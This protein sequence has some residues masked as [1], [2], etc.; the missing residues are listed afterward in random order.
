VTTNLV[1]NA[2]RH[3]PARARVTVR[4]GRLARLPAGA[5]QVR[6]G[7]VTVPAG[8]PL[9]VL[10]V[11]DDGPGVPSAHAARVFER[12]Y[13]ADS[14]RSRGTGGGSGLGLSIVAAI[15][16]G[17]GGWVELDSPP[18]GGATFRVILPLTA[19]PG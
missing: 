4:V 2:L 13:R 3:T 19:D 5:P 1:A 15:V 6:S 11:S 7:P 8:V 12:L 9:A 16:H 14:S 17:H 10:E 18:G